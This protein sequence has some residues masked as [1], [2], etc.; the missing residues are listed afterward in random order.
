[1]RRGA[2]H[3][4]PL[5]L[6]LLAGLAVLGL[7]GCDTP[8]AGSANEVNLTQTD[9]AQHTVTIPAGTAVRFNNP[10]SGIMHVLCVGDNS[11]CAPNPQGPTE[12]T[13]SDGLTLAAGQT[14]DVT[15]DTPGTY[16]IACVLHPAMNLTVTVT[17][18]S[19]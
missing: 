6:L 8:Q 17:E 7:A 9:F 16:T 10:A 15:F 14:K 11:R 3:T 18:R 13:A 5:L 12:L 4:L 2:M 1:M 19:A